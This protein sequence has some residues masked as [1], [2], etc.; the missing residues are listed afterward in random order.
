MRE[1][2]VRSLGWED[3]L[4][5]RKATHSSILAWRILGRKEWDTTERLSLSLAR[6]SQLGVKRCE[7][8]YN[9]KKERKNVVKGLPAGPVVKSPPC[10]ARDRRFQ[11]PR[12]N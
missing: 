11:V 5:K 3:T 7:N 6:S 8:S 2:W 12:G 9:A 10:N 4:E 1:T